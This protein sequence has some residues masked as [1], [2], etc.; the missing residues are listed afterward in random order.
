MNRNLLE[1]F[2]DSETRVVRALESLYRGN[3]VIVVDDES[4]ENEG[5]VI[6]GARTLTVGQMALMIRETSGIVCLCLPPEK[7]KSLDLP[8]MTERNTSAHGTAFTVSIDAAAGVT[9]GV[10]AADRVATVKAATADG[11]RPEDLSRP[12]HIFP[13]VAKPGGVLERRGHTECVVDL[14]RLAGLHPYGILGEVTNPDGTMARLPELVPFARKNALPLLS[15]E[16]VCGY[17]KK[18]SA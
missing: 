5:D 15:V 12:G 18:Y 11:A 14:M 10:S 3:G 8:M 2:G 1:D 4:R 7:V 16:D 13:L 9:T 6:Y 17:R